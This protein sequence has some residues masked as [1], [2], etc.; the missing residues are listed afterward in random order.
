MD[1][2]I[3]IAFI[4][5]FINV[6][7]RTSAAVAQMLV[8][9]VL[10]VVLVEY[11]NGYAYEYTNVSRRAIIN[12]LMNKSMSLGFWVNRNCKQAARTL[13]MDLNFYTTDGENR[14]AAGFIG[15]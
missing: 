9:P 1:P 11:A 5:M 13:T 6:A 8:S 15:A 12:L 4:H 3:H 7:P 2:L 14:G 10:G